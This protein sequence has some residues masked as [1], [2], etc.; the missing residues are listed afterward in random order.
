MTDMLARFVADP[1]MV[2]EN[3]G[4]YMFFEVLNKPSDLGAIGLAASDDGI[5]W[6][7]QQIVLKAPFHLSYP[8]VFKWQ[9][10][11]YMLPESRQSG[12]VKLYKADLFPTKWT[13][14]RDL[15]VGSYA[16]PS[17]IHKD[18]IWWLF[19]LRGFDTL[20]L[21]YAD[22]LIGPWVQHPA[23]PLAVG[24]KQIARPGGRLIVHDGKVI[25]YAQDCLPEYGRSLRAFQIDTLTKTDYAEHELP[26]SPILT[27]SGSGWNAAGM[28]HI[29]PHQLS[30][31]EWIA[32]VDGKT[33]KLVFDLK[34]GAERLKHDA[35]QWVK[36]VIRYDKQN[37]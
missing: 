31:T 21:F 35:K 15:I 1:F 14:V 8:Y 19:V 24:N 34:S 16:E 23:S 22:E 2:R 9:N 28:H 3:S 17:I 5:N 37:K 13:F 6:L 10:A 27:A 32:C 7:Y 12:A 25:R 4:W 20:A 18:G 11:H 36:K 29:D 33:K 26:D 30:E